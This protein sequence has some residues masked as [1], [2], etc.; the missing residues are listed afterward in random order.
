[1]KPR[2]VKERRELFLGAL[3]AAVGDSDHLEIEQLLESGIVAGRDHGVDDHEP[4]CRRNHAAAVAEDPHAGVVGP[5]VEDVL[6]QI[7]VAA[8]GN[9]V[10]EAS[11]F[12]DDAPL[13]RC[14]GEALARARNHVVEVVHD[15]ANGGVLLQNRGEQRAIAA[16]DVD[17]RATVAEIVGGQHRRNL[18]RRDAVH[19]L[20]EGGGLCG[21]GLQVLEEALAEDATKRWLAGADAGRE[22]GPGEHRRARPSVAR[23]AAER[24]RD[25][26]AQRIAERRLTKSPLRVLGEDADARERSQQAVQRVRVRADPRGKRRRRERPVVER[27]GDPELRGGADRLRHPAAGHHP[28]DHGCRRDLGSGGG[29][30]S[31]AH[32]AVPPDVL[33]SAQSW[34]QRS[35][36]VAQSPPRLGS[37]CAM[38]A[39]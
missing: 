2:G 32:G 8:G 36:D 19:R 24:P 38:H 18:R 17:D 33:C 29:S 34:W 20:V 28:H 31:R 9:G 27:V 11:C 25:A 21:R 6:H 12:D 13:E 4:P 22:V 35:D 37:S 39:V 23:P 16:A 30:I 3:A 26:G 7:R 14:A 15:A 10:E 5:V 1:M